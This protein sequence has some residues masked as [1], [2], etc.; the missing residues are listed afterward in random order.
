MADTLLTL[1]RFRCLKITIEEPKTAGEAL[2][3]T[4]RFVEVTLKGTLVNA[5]GSPAKRRVS[6]SAEWMRS[7]EA[8]LV[9]N[10]S[11]RGKY[12]LKATA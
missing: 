5:L 1:T 7:V 10:L 8:M 6:I 2:G 3:I 11:A 12:A 4:A 9:C